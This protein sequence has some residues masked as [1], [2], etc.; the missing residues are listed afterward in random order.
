MSHQHFLCVFSRQ[1][2]SL[3]TIKNSTNSLKHICGFKKHL[4]QFLGVFRI[5]SIQCQIHATECNPG[6]CWLCCLLSSCLEIGLWWDFSLRKLLWC[7]T[8]LWQALII[9]QYHRPP[10]ST[11]L[12]SQE[13]EEEARLWPATPTHDTCSVGHSARGATSV[14]ARVSWVVGHQAV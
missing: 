7:G 9:G 1:W 13:R 14:K 10:T 8:G 3:R 4:F 6:L 2:Q 5:C 11:A 12:P